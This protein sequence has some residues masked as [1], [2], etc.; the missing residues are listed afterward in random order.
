[1]KF[2]RILPVR[3]RIHAAAADNEA[4]VR[5]RL[6]LPPPAP[7]VARLHAGGWSFE[8][9]LLAPLHSQFH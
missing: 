6:S 2:G 7:T 8:T 1:V 9:M 3:R 5:R 4:R